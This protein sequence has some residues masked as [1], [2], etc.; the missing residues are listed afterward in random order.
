LE[1]HIAD[2]I[3]TVESD[4]MVWFTDHAVGV[5]THGAAVG[6]SVGDRS[7]REGG[8]ASRVTQVIDIAVVKR[9]AF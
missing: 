3:P 6:L 8:R 4:L 2:Y 7:W 1:H 5:T 9:W